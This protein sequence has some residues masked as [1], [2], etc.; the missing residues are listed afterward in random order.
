MSL[1]RKPTYI[2]STNG[3]LVGDEA[4]LGIGFQTIY[5]VQND[6]S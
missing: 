2:L 5:G 3:L 1:T 4:Q 6:N